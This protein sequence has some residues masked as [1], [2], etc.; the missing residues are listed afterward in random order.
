MPEGKAH[1]WVEYLQPGVA[2]KSLDKHP[3]PQDFLA[4]S[5]E[6]GQRDGEQDQGQRRFDE[7]FSVHRQRDQRND[8]PEQGGRPVLGTKERRMILQKI[9]KVTSAYPTNRDCQS[10]NQPVNRETQQIPH[11]L[12]KPTR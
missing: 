7:T 12:A 3:A 2:G 10:K 1:C 9:G 6:R 5:I 8:D 11:I 4:K